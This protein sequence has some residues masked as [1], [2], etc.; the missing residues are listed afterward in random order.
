[1]NTA[2]KKGSKSECVYSGSGKM[3]LLCSA[4]A[5]IGLAI[6]TL[7]EHTYMLIAITNSSPTLFTWEWNPDSPSA[8]SLT[9]QAGFFFI[10][11]W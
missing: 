7:V 6:A 4:C 11:T 5:F 8:K 2:D 10:T 3:P 9:W 1:M